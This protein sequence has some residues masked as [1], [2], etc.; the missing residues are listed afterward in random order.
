MMT[1]IT[2]IMSNSSSTERTLARDS[3]SYRITN[4]T[5][6]CSNSSRNSKNSD[7]FK[8]YYEFNEPPK[9]HS[10]STSRN[11]SNKPNYSKAT[12]HNAPVEI[13]LSNSYMYIQPMQQMSMSTFLQPDYGFDVIKSTETPNGV[14]NDCKKHLLEESVLEIKSALK[15]VYNRGKALGLYE[16][17]M[18]KYIM[19]NAFESLTDSETDEEEVNQYTNT[20]QKRVK[21]LKK[22]RFNSFEWDLI[23]AFPSHWKPV[24]KGQGLPA[25]FILAWFNFRLQKL[26][27]RLWRAQSRR[28]GYVKDLYGIGTAYGCWVQR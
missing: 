13:M 17:D 11:L 25:D 2:T 12:H 21:R 19:K 28:W 20:S 26:N 6:T 1:A 8:N 10:N 7:Y 5:R 18:M 24:K 9:A 16:Q 14:N 15:R 3:Y 23:R 22:P 4:R 27:L